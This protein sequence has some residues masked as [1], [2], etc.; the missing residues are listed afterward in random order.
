MK[1][2]NYN[3]RESKLVRFF[4]WYYEN[5]YLLTEKI[6]IDKK[7]NINLYINKK[8]FRKN[9][10]IPH[11]QLKEFGDFKLYGRTYNIFNFILYKLHLP[12]KFY[13]L[14]TSNLKNNDIL[15]LS[16]EVEF[17]YIIYTYILSHFKK[18]RYILHLSQTSVNSW[19]SKWFFIRWISKK[20]VQN[21]S[22]IIT[23][24][25]IA[26]TRLYK[27]KYLTPHY[28][29]PII[30]TGQPINTKSFK[31][32]PESQIQNIKSAYNIL[33]N[34]KVILF[35]GKITPQK[36][37]HILIKALYVL[38]KK[39]NFDDFKLLIIGKSV[40]IYYTKYLENLANIYEVTN[41]IIWLGYQIR[42]N[43]VLYYNLADVLVLPSINIKGENIEAFGIV[44]LEALSCGIPVIGSEI[45]GIKEIIKHNKNGFL[46]REGDYD[47]LAKCLKKI[48]DNE[49]LMKEMGKF[50][51]EFVL[52]KYSFS[53]LVDKYYKF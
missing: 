25:E 42:E 6:Y 22:G 43:L 16:G 37:I 31:L 50:G 40:E 17:F 48:I 33:N 7:L 47:S 13:P 32:L 34:E 44:L 4:P 29:I 3:E 41:N 45:G 20:V 24:T 30:I 35:V 12:I 9:I 14:I 5:Q 38:K 8:E 28:K 39:Y 2:H 18:I 53:I 51:R 10:R 19:Y 49:D 23:M 11:M 21:A 1:I 15:E 46:F 52:K 36:G 27:I 26:K